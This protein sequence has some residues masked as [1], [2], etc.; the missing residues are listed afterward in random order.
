MGYF[1]YMS[2]IPDIIQSDIVTQQWDAFW[3][4][5]PDSLNIGSEQ[6]NTLV[7]TLP[8]TQ[9]SAEETALLKMM[10][11]C[12]FGAE[13]YKIVQMQPEMLV[14]WHKI[15]E[16]ANPKN[17]ILLG[18]LPQQLGITVLLRLFN[19]NRFDGCIWIPGLSLTDM[20]KQPE[21]KKELW[22]NGLKPTFVD[23]VNG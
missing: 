18:V 21:A 22:L 4:P 5:L 20:E 16:V 6:T 10:Q 17:V 1:Q 9:G 8:Y 7:L 15:K 13:G 11:A 14:A 2:Q 12:K 23:A 3:N 19:P